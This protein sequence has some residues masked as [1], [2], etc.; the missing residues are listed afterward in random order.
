MMKGMAAPKRLSTNG[1]VISASEIRSHSLSSA[2]DK[3]VQRLTGI[4]LELNDRKGR[5]SSAFDR[6]VNSVI[7]VVTT[8][9]TSVSPGSARITDG[10][11]FG[12]STTSRVDHLR[13][14]QLLKGSVRIAGGVQQ[15]P[16]T[17]LFPNT[18]GS[19]FG[20]LPGNHS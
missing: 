10:A 8:G 7:H 16:G 6:R 13:D 19:S 5:I 15:V 1:V 4:L 9:L 14:R 20:R 2:L 18:R 11:S 17:R 12:Q 3:V